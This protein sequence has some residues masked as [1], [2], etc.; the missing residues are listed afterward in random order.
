MNIAE[1]L[2]KYGK[3]GDELYSTLYG[4]VTLKEIGAREN[5]YPI[6]VKTPTG[7]N[8]AFS[9]CGQFSPLEPDGECILFPSQECRDWDEYVR[10]KEDVKAKVG[11]HVW[12]DG[13]QCIIMEIIGE[14]VDIAHVIYGCRNRVFLKDLTIADKFDHTKLCTFDRVLVRDTDSDYWKA[15]I[16]SHISSKKETCGIESNYYKYSC[17]HDAYC[18]CIPYNDETKHLVGTDDKAPE[19][20]RE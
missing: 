12:Y 3:E 7:A 5:I 2:R 19:F 13:D 15:N 8:A 9:C 6:V 17:V 20:Y 1:I 11:D 16:F 10:L 18:K 4:K 14:E